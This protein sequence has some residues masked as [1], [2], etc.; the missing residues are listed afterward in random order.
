M[1]IVDGS[2]IVVDEQFMFGVATGLHVVAHVY[3]VAVQYHCPCIGVGKADLPLAALLQLF[4]YVAVFFL[5]GLLVFYFVP[6][7]Q[8][9]KKTGR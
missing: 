8:V 4:F 7:A 3:D 1:G 5:F 6:V 9:R 2:R